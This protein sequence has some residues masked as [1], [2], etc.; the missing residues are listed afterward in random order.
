MAHQ[1]RPLEPHLTLHVTSHASGARL[2]FPT[3]G[4]REQFKGI[5]V[6]LIKTIPVEIHAFAM[7]DNHVHLMLT[8]RDE[9]AVAAFMRRLQSSHAMS[10][11]RA[12]AYRGQ[13][14]LDRYHTTIIETESHALHTC[15]YIYANPWRARVVDHPIDSRWTSHR[16]LVLGNEA[17]FVKPHQ[18]LL[19]LGSGDEWRGRYNEIMTEYLRRGSRS[20]CTGRRTSGEDPL[21]GLRLSTWTM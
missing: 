16:E 17:S 7:M 14:W 20:C 4:T 15:L 18:V 19:D 12:E 11:N 9:G 1:L 6:R 8:A 5:I 10:L 3:D 13:L 21:A 2:C